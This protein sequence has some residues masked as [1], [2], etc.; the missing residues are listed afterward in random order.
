MSQKFYRF[1]YTNPPREG[2]PR[3]HHSR[4]G[5]AFNELTDL[6]YARGYR[7]GTFIHNYPNHRLKAKE[8]AFLQPGDLVVATTRPPLDDF[9][10]GKEKDWRR[11]ERSNDDLEKAISKNLRRF[12]K[13]VS[14][15]STVLSPETSR[16]LPSDFSS[17][18]SINFH[19]KGK[20]T[21]ASIE[22]T[23]GGRARNLNAPKDFNTV[24]FFLHLPQITGY[25][26]GL[27]AS[28]SMG[29]AAR[30]R[31]R[32]AQTAHRTSSAP[33]PHDCRRRPR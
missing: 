27:V 15:Y 3:L 29:G 1:G 28:F 14:R 25:P 20:G 9:H 13:H 26:C 2:Q 7:Y 6:L 16:L 8:F 18:A 23:R 33:D 24:G 22:V 4:D 17:L 19:T 31:F 11:I 30:F 21:I 12:F 10:E 32:P 5:A